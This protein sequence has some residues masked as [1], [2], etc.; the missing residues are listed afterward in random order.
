MLPIIQILLFSSLSF[1]KDDKFYTFQNDNTNNSINIVNYLIHQKRNFI[2]GNKAF[3][4]LYYTTNLNKLWFQKNY[5]YDAYVVNFYKYPKGYIM[6]SSTKIKNNQVS[7]RIPNKYFFNSLDNLT[8]TFVSG[9]I[10][11]NDTYLFHYNFTNSNNHLTH[12]TTHFLNHIN[13]TN[14]K[15]VYIKKNFIKNTFIFY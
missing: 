2:I 7:L 14:F 8:K 4:Q 9:Y 11:N 1:N 3:I 15:N 5:N 12:T 6:K 10:Y 13:N